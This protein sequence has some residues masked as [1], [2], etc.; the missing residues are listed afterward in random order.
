MRHGGRKGA[1]NKKPVM[2]NVYVVDKTKQPKANSVSKTAEDDLKEFVLKINRSSNGAPIL[3][4][5]GIE[6][7]DEDWLYNAHTRNHV[8]LADR[9]QAADFSSPLSDQHQVIKS[10]TIK[11]S[12]SFFGPLIDMHLRMFLEHPYF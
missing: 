2:K 5:E 12:E 4:T 1:R 6:K 11:N 8:S 9:S 10:W 7:S 3:V